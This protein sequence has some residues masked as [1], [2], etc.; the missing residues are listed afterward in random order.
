MERG[1]KRRRK[2]SSM[3]KRTMQYSSYG[4]PMVQR[5]PGSGTFGRRLK[6]ERFR[7]GF[8]LEEFAGAVGCAVCTVTAA[9]NRNVMP[10]LRIVI[11]MAQVLNCSIDYL[12]GL[13]D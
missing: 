2:G 4:K 1:L 10:R 7:R 9:E 12:V 8:T 5:K 13:E 3:S 6:D 11:E